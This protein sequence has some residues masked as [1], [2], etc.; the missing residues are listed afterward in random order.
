MFRLADRIFVCFI[1]ALLLSA[2]GRSD[3]ADDS[4][5]EPDQTRGA[6]SSDDWFKDGV[7]RFYLAHLDSGGLI[8]P[9]Y[10]YTYGDRF[11]FGI[12]CYGEHE[13][14][15][16]LTE[17]PARKGSKQKIKIPLNERTKLYQFPI[18]NF[19]KP[20]KGLCKILLGSKKTPRQ[21]ANGES[22]RTGGDANSVVERVVYASL[23][24]TSMIAAGIKFVGTLLAGG[25]ATAQ[26]GGV[27]APVAASAI[28]I[29][30]AGTISSGLVC[31]F[32]VQSSID[33][34][35]EYQLKQNH[36]LLSRALDRATDL[37]I[38]SLDQSGMLSVYNKLA[39]S[40]SNHVLAGAIWNK[41]FVKT[42]NKSIDDRFENGWGRGT[43]FFDA[44]EK[45]QTEF[46]T[47]VANLNR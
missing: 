6:L 45:V 7:D 43:K 35:R 16:A 34:V 26:T 11:F 29:D 46:S 10:D 2:A 42:F 17:V 23:G 22:L 33:A 13:D 5:I 3:P 25:Y 19:D 41:E 31:A 12:G 21:I 40:G 30:G 8:E 24:C 32:K 36:R 37:T 39:L 14:P 47:G 9:D 1:G 4:S 38:E 18:S 20:E 44:V 27:A 28:A 15:E